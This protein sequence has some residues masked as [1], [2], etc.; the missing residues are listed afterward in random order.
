[1]RL[2]NPLWIGFAI[3]TVMAATTSCGKSQDGGGRSSIEGRD[4]QGAP[5]PAQPPPTTAVDAG[6]SEAT[7]DCTA[8]DACSDV[9]CAREASC[10][11]TTESRQPCD[12]FAQNCTDVAERCYPDQTAT[13][14]GRCYREGTRRVGQTCDEPPYGEPEACRKGLLCVVTSEDPGVSGVCATVCRVAGSDCGPD[15][16]CAALDAGADVSFS[17]GVCVVAPPVPVVP[18]DAVSQARC[19]APQLCAISEHDGNT[20][21]PAGRGGAGAACA[22]PSG[23]QRGLQCAAVAGW[24]PTETWLTVNDGYVSRGE[25][26]CLRPCSTANACD[27]GDACSPISGDNGN[28]RPDMRL[29][30]PDAGR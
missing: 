7:L 10:Q 26:V 21:V 30:Y 17:F 27:T 20:C 2:R 4:G 29:C 13:T 8:R 14:D 6:P 16:L 18:C 12:V 15:G 22:G 24:T 19:D 3:A 11:A 5:P 23:C 28:A 9:R 25:G 1:M